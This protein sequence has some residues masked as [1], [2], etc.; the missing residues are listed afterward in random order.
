MSIAFRL[1]LRPFLRR[2]APSSEKRVLLVRDDVI[3]DLLVPTSA[4]VHW[5]LAQGYDVYLVLRKDL[6]DIGELL[7]PRDRLLPV[8][9]RLE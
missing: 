4:V 6:M 2:S 3:G 7:L 1:P 9:I 8:D 5:L